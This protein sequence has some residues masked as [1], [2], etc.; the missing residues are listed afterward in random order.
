MG[1]V[2]PPTCLMNQW[3]DHSQVLSFV[4][5]LVPDLMNE[6]RVVKVMYVCMYVCMVAVGAK[7]P[8]HS[9]TVHSPLSCAYPLLMYCVGL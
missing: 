4:I 6:V 1:P 7:E 3:F 2:G 8:V 9:K 5:H